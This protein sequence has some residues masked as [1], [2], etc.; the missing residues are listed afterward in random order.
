MFPEV[1]IATHLIYSSN[2]ILNLGMKF[3]YFEMC[4]N[5]LEIYY[6]RKRLS[7]CILLHI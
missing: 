4:P 2:Y 7:N 1:Q 6:V 5:I 3:F